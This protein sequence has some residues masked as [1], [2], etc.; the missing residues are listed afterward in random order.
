MGGKR[1]KRVRLATGIFSDPWGVS[2]IVRGKE[3]RYPLGT[4]LEQL[5]R[6]RRELV[7]AAGAA[8]ARRGTLAAAVKTYLETIPEGSSRRRDVTTM[9]QHWLDAGLGHL[10]LDAVKPIDIRTQLAAWPKFS[11]KTKN[12]L[13]QVLGAVYNVV[14]GRSGYNP[15]RDV[16]RQKV[17]YDEPRG[18][19]LE[20]AERI[21]QAIP[22]RGRPTGAGKGTR[23]KVN[24]SKLRLTVM[25]YTGLS[26]AM[27]KRVQPRDFDPRAKTLFVRPRQKGH[28]VDA[29]TVPLIDEAVRAFKALAQAKAWGAFSTRSLAKVWNGSVTR[30][31]V[32]WE[33]AEAKKRTPK[34]WP[35]VNDARPYDLRHTFGTLILAETG[36]LE[37]T[38]MLLRH[39]GLQ[40][41]RRYAQAAAQ[42]RARRATLAVN[43]V[44][45]RRQ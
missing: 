9:L 30:T 33:A 3:H 6:D 16:P 39:A 8:P 23:P 42:L 22:D 26:Q 18:M 35:L 7:D 43:S 20:L 45:G 15:V 34:P 41:T 36:D 2:V 31:K 29:A 44:L 12:D 40:Q 17:R 19:S 28:G 4:P 37:A 11:P 25:V 27:L 21:L 32:A 5:R 10:A 13:R 38:A 24:L 1:T 14:N